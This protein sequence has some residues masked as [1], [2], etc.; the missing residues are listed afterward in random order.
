[1]MKYLFSMKNVLFLFLASILFV[2]TTFGQTADEEFAIL[3]KHVGIAD[4]ATFETQRIDWKNPKTKPLKIYLALGIDMTVTDNYAR[5]IAEWNRKNAA[6]YGSVAVVDSVADADIILVRYVERSSPSTETTSSV[7]S[8]TV[9]NPATNSTVTRPV[10][11]QYST[12]IAPVYTYILQ[13]LGGGRFA[14]TYR[15]ADTATFRSTKR[16]GRNLW[17]DF[18]DILKERK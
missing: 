14:I 4:S 5:W 2:A 18:E 7:S 6:K 15:D 3:K 8:A 10:T 13:P 16:S 9:W 12:T 1:M 11:R 17:E